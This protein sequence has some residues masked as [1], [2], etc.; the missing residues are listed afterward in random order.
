MEKAIR[1]Q[2]QKVWPQGVAWLLLQFLPVWPGF[3]YKSVAYKKARTLN[4]YV[5][6]SRSNKTP[7]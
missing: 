6:D 2:T 4:E 5:N 7:V 1:F 3:A